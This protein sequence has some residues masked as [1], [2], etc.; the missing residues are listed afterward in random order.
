M[1][2][3][4]PVACVCVCSKDLYLAAHVER[5]WQGDSPDVEKDHAEANLVKFST[6]AD[7]IH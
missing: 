1:L 7:V 5:I 6:D 4:H 2:V 3:L